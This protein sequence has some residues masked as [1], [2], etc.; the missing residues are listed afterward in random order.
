MIRA[1]ITRKCLY[2]DGPELVTIAP[3]SPPQFIKSGSDFNLSCTAVSSPAATFQWFHN[4]QLMKNSGPTLT[5][6][7]IQ[8]LGFGSKAGQ[9]SC[10][11]N[12]D[13]T[14]RAVASAAV[15]LAVMGECP[16]ADVPGDVL[17]QLPDG[18]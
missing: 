18:K 1:A 7:K 5:L 2:P 8:E 14:K 6:K 16:P 10:G 12:N 9:Y 11:A 17:G 4:Q 13:K 15:S 3:P